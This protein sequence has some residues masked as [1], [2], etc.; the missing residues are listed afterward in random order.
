[1]RIGFLITARMKSTRLAKKLTLEINGRQIIRWM[2]DRLKQCPSIDDI[3]ICTSTNQQDNILVEIASEEGIKVFRGS[4]EDVIQR[5]YEASKYYNVEYALNITADCPLVS[6]EYIDITIDKYKQTNADLIRSLELPH[7][8]FL[9]GLKVEAMQK[10]CEIK[11]GTNTEVWGKYFTDTALFNVLDIEIPDDLKRPD[12]RLTL[13][14]PDDYEFFKRIYTHF[15]QYTYKKSIY[16]I[17]GFIDE[18]PEIVQINKHCKQLYKE[19][20]DQQ[21]NIQV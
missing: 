10:V 4:E 2:I 1:M 18:H 21:N 15:G 6:L 3:I 20:F 7:G 14:Y 19:R 9:Y 17:I 11:K 13:D 8:F 16:E 12:Y 5:L